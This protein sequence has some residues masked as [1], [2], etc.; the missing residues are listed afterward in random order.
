M[1]HL[2]IILASTSKYRAQCLEK[3]NIPFKQ[4]SP[5]CAE[6]SKNNET[7]KTLSLR[8]SIEKAKS[9]KNQFPEHLI[10]GSDQTCSFD[11][12]E[13]IGKP[14]NFEN[15]KTQLLKASG[16]CMHFYTG[17]CVYDS[18]NDTF[19][20]SV[21]TYTVFFRELSELEIEDYLKQDQPYDCAGSFKA[22]GLGI[23]LF[24]KLQ[25]DDPN[26]LIGLP[27]IA[28]SKILRQKNQ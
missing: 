19:N 25:G 18:K 9:L 21:E 8:L 23:T 27:L 15:A 28:L 26:S 1:S 7:P 13:I 12:I 16:K 4:A 22:E 20:A 14:G 6:I 3:L 17:L 10:I 2:P 11:D 24:E 5:I